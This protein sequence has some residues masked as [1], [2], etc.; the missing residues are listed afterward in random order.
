LYQAT[1]TQRTFGKRLLPPAAPISDAVCLSGSINGTMLAGKTYNVCGDIF[2]NQ[3]DS[4]IIQEGVTINFKGTTVPVG[5]GVKGKLI[6]L[7]TKE[8]PVLF[9]VLGVNKTDQLGS[10]SG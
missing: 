8:K 7:G 3:T 4:L 5:L 6:S 10:K 9:T 1:E 2:V